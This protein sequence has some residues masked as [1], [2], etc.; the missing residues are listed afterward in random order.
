MH[1]SVKVPF[2]SPSAGGAHVSRTQ[3]AELR[4]SRLGGATILEG[5]GLMARCTLLAVIGLLFGDAAAAD[6]AKN[7]QDAIQGRWVVE[8][9]VFDGKPTP[10]DDY[11]HLRL[12]IKGDK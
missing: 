4:I 11:K 3:R 7:D 2:V 6:D 8:S 12:E 9:I 5:M 10:E 1:G